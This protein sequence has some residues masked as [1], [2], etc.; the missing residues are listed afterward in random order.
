MP[1]IQRRRGP[2]TRAPEPFAYRPPWWLAA[3]LA[4]GEYHP[5]ITYGE[6]ARVADAWS[7]GSWV[8]LF[9]AGSASARPPSPI[10]ASR[11]AMS[12]S[13][14]TAIRPGSEVR[15]RR[16]PSCPKRRIL[17]DSW[18]RYEREAR[19]HTGRGRGAPGGLLGEPD[20]SPP[21][22]RPPGGR[23]PARRAERRRG[24]KLAHCLPQWA[25]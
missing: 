10:A 23:G 15:I 12:P 18:R 25:L 7:C 13:W 9:T 11:T 17:A 5:H 1:G 24:A 6:V 20:P 3:A 19:G 21:R 16:R 4:T 22:A 2:T 8:E 14:S